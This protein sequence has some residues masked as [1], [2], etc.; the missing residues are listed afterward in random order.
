MT[1]AQKNSVGHLKQTSITGVSLPFVVKLMLIFN[2]LPDALSFFIGGMRLTVVRVLFL[3]STPVLLSR[4]A[5]R[6]AEGTYRIIPSDVFVILAGMWMFVSAAQV[7]GI[8][9]SF[10]HSGPIALE[11]CVG[12]WSMRLLLTTPEHTRRAAS[13]LCNTIT[14]VALLGIMDSLTNHYVIR[15]WLNTVLHS[16][17]VMDGGGLERRHGILRATGPVEHPILFGFICGIGFLLSVSS[18][19]MA[20]AVICGVGTVVSFSAGG[21]LA[22]AFGAA[23][24]AYDFVFSNVK[25][26]W[27]ILIGMLVIAFLMLMIASNDPVGIIVRHL[28][29]DPGSGYDRLLQW[30]VAGGMLLDESPWFGL[31]FVLPEQLDDQLISATHSI[32]SLWLFSA[33]EYGIVGS[34]LIGATLLG[35]TLR[36]P[37]GTVV[38][39]PA[40]DLRLRSCLSIVLCVTVLVGFVVHLWG[41]AWILVAMLAGMRANLGELHQRAR[42]PFAARKDPGSV[43]LRPLKRPNIA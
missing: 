23:L 29:F 2:F 40:A 39:P 9:S 24:I 14:F 1:N 13:L 6:I 25:M 20:L 41:T 28:T 8:Q 18:R 16:N 10:A 33:L 37:L 11:F 5:T 7:D 19:R 4:L 30:H 31:G 22:T 27:R 35:S 43:T 12:Y 32:D 34:A 21:V 15:E 17:L 3:W 36:P 26:R 38:Q 42:S